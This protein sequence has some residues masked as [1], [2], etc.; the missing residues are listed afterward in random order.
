MADVSVINVTSLTPIVAA[1]I[2]SG[3]QVTIYDQG[4]IAYRAP[5]EDVFSAMKTLGGDYGVKAA[6]LTIARA[7][8]LTL[9]ATPVA[10][11]LTVPAGYIPLLISAPMFSS[12]FVSAAYAANTAIR[13]RSTG[14]SVDIVASTSVLDFTATTLRLLDIQGGADN[15]LLY[16]DGADLEVYVPTGDPTTGDSDITITLMYILMPTP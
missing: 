15:T 6:T 2:V 10:F 3:Q 16:L 5:I 11:G 12:T 14:G 13:I 4:G 7:D 9:N 8:V 1:A